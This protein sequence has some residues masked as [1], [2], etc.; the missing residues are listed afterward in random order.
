[1]RSAKYYQTLVLSGKITVE[2]DHFP[3]GILVVIVKHENASLCAASGNP[4][5][6]LI[7]LDEK[8]K[9]EKTLE[10]KPSNLES[11]VYV[12]WSSSSS[13]YIWGLSAPLSFIGFMCAISLVILARKINAHSLEK[14]KVAG[15]ANQ[16]IDTRPDKDIKFHHNPILFVGAFYIVPLGKQIIVLTRLV[17]SNGN[18]DL[19]FSNFGCSKPYSWISDLNHAYSNLAFILLGILAFVIIHRWEMSRGFEWRNSICKTGQLRILYAMAWTMMMEG[20]LR[21]SYHVCPNSSTF[22][23]GRLQNS[24]IMK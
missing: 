9:K 23:T 13:P 16:E 3:N 15:E 20:L 18:Q 24:S 2:R 5:R 12:S 17:L 6:N 11:L 19:C 21:G 22:Y 7:S 10:D 4:N 14:E 8:F 1:M